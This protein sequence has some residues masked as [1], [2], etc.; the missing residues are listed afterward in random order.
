MPFGLNDTQNI[1][2]PVGQNAEQIAGMTN[3]L[4]IGVIEMVRRVDSAIAAL[5]TQDSLIAELT[6]DTT[7]DFIS[8]RGRQDK[9][10][11][12]GAEYTPG[13]PQ[14]GGGGG[15]FHLGIYN[16]EIDLGFT[17][18]GLMV[19]P[20]EQFEEELRT[21]VQAV[22]RGRR[23]DVLERFFFPGEM[24]LNDDGEGLTPGFAGSG[25]GGNVFSGYLPNGQPTP[26]GYTHYHQADNTDVA[27]DAA[28]KTALRKMQNFNGQVCDMLGSQQF[29][30][31][32]T[33]I[34]GDDKFVPA[35]SSL[36]RPA[37][38]QTQALVDAQQYL[39]VYAGFIRVRPPDAQ[40]E[41]M[42]GALV[43]SYGRGNSNNPLAWRWDPLFGRGA[44]VDDRSLTPLAEAMV[45]QTY[46][47]NVSNRTAAAF[48]SIGGT[49]GTYA[50]PTILR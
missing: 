20:L 29:I 24:P 27:I 47:V 16:Y 21:T 1:Y 11:H 2:F 30:E 15:G 50:P 43:K 33:A 37:E 10:W 14:R 12:R 25:T 18:R 31:R 3:R 41:G 9:I 28:I 42:S 7:K 6:Y 22:A 23:A 13:R 40:I 36:I 38:A 46:G 32:V 19:M 35:G 44:W 17:E 49:P 4:G 26:V 8:T 45:M 48:L 34:L 5:N 39:G